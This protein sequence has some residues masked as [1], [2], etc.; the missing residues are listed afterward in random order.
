MKKREGPWP[1][2]VKS[3]ARSRKSFVL[4]E[5]QRQL[6]KEKKNLFG[7]W[8]LEGDNTCTEE[9]AEDAV[10]DRGWELKKKKLSSP[11][12]ATEN[13]T[14][15]TSESPGPVWHLLFFIQMFSP[16]YLPFPQILHLIALTLFRKLD[17]NTVILWVPVR[18]LIPKSL[19]KTIFR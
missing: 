16:I 5:T 13:S 7:M 2:R 18:R 12:G 6:E 8:T 15:I 9:T 10:P 14:S 11:F 3:R 19:Q 1:W 4:L 17:C